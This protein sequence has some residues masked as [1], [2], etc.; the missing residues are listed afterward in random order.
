MGVRSLKGQKMPTEYI[1]NE[2]GSIIRRTTTDQELDVSHRLTAVLMKSASIVTPRMFE[3][4][5]YGMVG[6]NAKPDSYSLTVPVKRLM[7]RAPWKLADGFLVP[8][9]SSSNDP[10]MTITWWVPEGMTLK[11][12]IAVQNYTESIFAMTNMWLFAI[13][14]RGA[15][16]RIPLAN[17]HDDCHVCHGQKD[18]IHQTLQGLVSV[19]LQR[20]EISKYNADLWKSAEQTQRFFRVKPGTKDSFEQQSI[21]GDWTKLCLKVATAACKLMI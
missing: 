10:I 9:F 7:I 4:P 2:T 15:T 14:S 19:C 20:F 21:D 11:M 8:N 3:I 12:L 16:Y 6:L 1:L 5:E 13:D 18:I 17:I